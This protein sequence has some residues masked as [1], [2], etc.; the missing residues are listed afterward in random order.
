M[1]LTQL[2]GAF[3]IFLLCPILGALPLIHWLT[4][5]LTGQNLKRLGTGNISV[6]AAFYHGGKVAGIF[7]VVSEAGKG[8]AVV[9]L[10][11]S[12]FPTDPVWELVALIA[13]VIGRYW[14]GK[15]A[16]TTNVMWGILAHDPLG[17][18]L[19]LLISGISFTVLRDRAAG[20]NGVLV[21]M[22]VIIGLR[23]INTPSHII[24]VMALS[25]LL[26]AIYYKIPDDLDLPSKDGKNSSM[27]KFFRGDRAIVSLDDVLKAK[28][29]GQKA[30]TLSQ[31][32]RWGYPVPTG[33]VL[34]AGDDPLPLLELA[35]PS[36]ENPLIVR[37]SAVGEDSEDSSAAGQYQSISHVTNREALKNGI[38]QCQASYNN[39]TAAQ[40]RRQ[41]QQGESAMAV[42]VQQQIQGVFSGVAF[43][44][45]PIT[46]M[47]EAVLIEALP[48]EATGVVSGQ[49]TPQQ[50]RVIPDSPPR[51]EGEGDMP[52]SLLQ[53]VAQLARELEDR[54]HGFP[55]DI[56]WTYDGEKLWI[57]QSRPITS[58][59]PI[60]TRKIAA[61]VIPGLIRPLTWSI[62]RPLTC[63]VWGKLFTL[64]LGDRAK[65][66]KFNETATLHYSRAYFNAT[67]LGKI[68]RRMGLPAESLEFL[69][70]GAKFTRPSVLSTLR[71]VPGLLRLGMREWR[72][73][74]DF[75]KDQDALF[76]PTLEELQQQPASELSPQQ[77]L[78]RMEMILTTLHSA[79]YYNIL[80]PLSFSLRKAVLKVE[81]NALDYNALPEVSSSQALA[82]IAQDA[83]N[84]VPMDTI[85]P[86]SAPSLFAMLAELPDG[87]SILEQFQDWL[88]QYGYLSE[89]ATDIAVPRWQENPRPARSL[90]T[91]FFFKEQ[92]THNK[93]GTKSKNHSWKENT[94][95]QR[96][97]LK[98]EV[99][100]VYNRL[101]AHLRW[102]F[103]ALERIWL[104]TGLLNEEGD[105]FFLKLSEV[106]HL[107]KNDDPKLRE[108]LSQRLRD[109]RSNFAEDEKLP[110]VPYVVYGNP[111]QRD[112]V[113]ISPQLRSQQR[114]QGIAASA[115]Q[116]IGRIKVV[117][118]LS[119]SIT[120]DKETILVVPYTDAGWGVVLA[121]AG[122]L[123]S[124]VGG[125]LSHG[126]IIA[127][128]YGLPA[129]MDIPNAIHLFQDGQ[130]VKIDGQTGMVELLE[131]EK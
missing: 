97:N 121:Q 103:L 64:V 60:W 9:L 73:E 126:A 24:A 102:S 52:E 4:L 86:M 78:T 19:I 96:L 68:F 6:S 91:Q 45:D 14:G 94:V 57:L 130:L 36:A 42:I 122:G 5:G 44:R 29:V 67:L 37:S 35:S 20:R 3:L 128:E 51:I 61:E 93:N 105:I 113:V 116:A 33:W 101:L 123:I 55:Q 23:N 27:F 70:R 22:T 107:V 56:E 112:S 47:D 124:E 26:F 114:W 39:P 2:G 88:K 46:Q 11:R 125:R 129:V 100:E 18:G 28:K 79:T 65:G 119:Q 87:E 110:A 92:P 34:P 58:L 62:N 1:T 41:K 30:A 43:S 16:G 83:R 13:L 40:Y 106:R 108:E 75:A 71:N 63:G 25:L 77:L 59:Q 99:A 76:H 10:A 90:F 109:R 21:L 69:T 31:L 95:Q 82:Q 120:L 81:D 17:A 15:G 111:P 7:A 84:L 48:G 115:G 12:F 8:I 54:F 85:E 89:T 50:Y 98:A 49:A 118:D 32:K 131:D 38:L 127:R 104:Q 72:L 80:S 66:L 53:D 117:Q 74:N